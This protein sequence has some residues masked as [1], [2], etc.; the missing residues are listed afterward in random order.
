MV[1]AIK[2]HL[3]LYKVA[4]EAVDNGQLSEFLDQLDRRVREVRAEPTFGE[5]ARDWER[6]CVVGGGLRESHVK[7]DQSILKFHLVPAFGKLPLS[8][9]DV[10]RIDRYKAEKAHAKHAR[11]IG[12]SLKTVNNHLSVLHR[13]FEKAIEYGFVEKNPVSKKAWVRSDQTAEDGRPWWTPEEEANAVAVLE[14]WCEK[15]PAIGLPLLTQLVTGVRFCELRA[16][17]KQDLDIQAS[18][19]WIRRAQPLN[20]ISTPKNGRSRFQVLPPQLTECLRVWMLKTEGQLLFPARSGCPL[21]N[22]PVN[23]AYARLAKE[24][25]VRRITSHGARH[26]SGSGY[27]MRGASQ[28]MIGALLGHADTKSTE[29]YVHVQAGATRSLVYER[30][31]KFGGRTPP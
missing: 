22:N 27:A 23:R 18:G 13:M 11:G 8:A 31:G 1:E 19:I 10:R 9:I 28:K 20:V 17:Q 5:F 4:K 3:D 6:D 12:Y 30:W 24:A 26:T 25:C 7:S 16:L 14:Q 29:R 2:A 21:S 15:E